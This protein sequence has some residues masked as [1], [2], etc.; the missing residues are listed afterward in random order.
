M[1]VGGGGA[2]L[3]V[4]LVVQPRAD[5]ES[6]A[7]WQYMDFLLQDHLEVRL[8]GGLCIVFSPICVTHASRT[9]RNVPLRLP[10]PF[11]SERPGHGAVPQAALPNAHDQRRAHDDGRVPVA[12]VQIQLLRALQSRVARR[13]HLREVPAVAQRKRQRR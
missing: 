6:C 7:L 1:V 3:F 8:A 4:S 11:F 13:H 10:P 9:L 2:G 12:V 5:V